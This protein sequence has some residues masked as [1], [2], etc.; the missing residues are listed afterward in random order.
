MLNLPT[1][2]GAGPV[3][4]R[5][6]AIVRHQPDINAG[7]RA[8]RPAIG[9]LRSSGTHP[10]IPPGRPGSG[11]Q[12]TGRSASGTGVVGAGRHG[13]GAHV[14]LGAMGISGPILGANDDL[15][16]VPPALKPPAHYDLFLETEAG[17]DDHKG[18][19]TFHTLTDQP[20]IGDGEILR[21]GQMHR[22]RY[23]HYE[24]PLSDNRG[25]VRI[26]DRGSF[27]WMP[28]SDPAEGQFWLT[29]DGG[30]LNGIFSISVQDSSPVQEGSPFQ[31]Q[32]QFSEFPG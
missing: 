21:M 27:R 4:W 7:I 22:R 12:R 10:A 8:S 2:V 26:V 11:A 30:L 20:P 13:S 1:V 23:L 14:S 9:A 16:D 17:D 28:Q 31:F 19:L 25:S 5:K 6:Y 29:M 24:G 18:L 3:I 32:F 15:P